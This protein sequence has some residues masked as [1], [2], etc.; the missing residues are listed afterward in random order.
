[1]GQNRIAYVT[2]KTYVQ[3]MQSEDL[4]EK[5]RDYQIVATH[6]IYMNMMGGWTEEEC[7]NVAYLVPESEQK[8][9]NL[10]FKKNGE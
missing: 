3:I 6:Y 8:T 7:D 10:E 5:F 9:L 4:K 2:P 1:M